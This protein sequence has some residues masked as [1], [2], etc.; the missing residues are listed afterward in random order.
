[1]PYLTHLLILFSI[2]AILALGLNLVVGLTG[3]VS[4][5]HAAFFGVGSYATA[6]LL[7]AS[8]IGFF[9]SLVIGMVIAG[10]L[11][12]I[13]ARILSELSWDYY[14]LGTVGFN[15]IIV[16]ILTNWRSLTRGPLGIPGI[17]R[18]AFLATNTEILVLSLV[19]LAAT[20]AVCSFVRASSF[21]RVLTAIR[22]DE[23]A[24]SVFGYRVVHYKAAVFVIAAALAAVAGSLNAVFITFISPKFDVTLSI[25]IFSVVIFGGLGNLRG[26]LVGALVLVLL[27]E[28]LRFVGFSEDIAA[29]VRQA[30]YGLA[31]V[32]LMLYRPQGIMGKYRL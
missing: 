7:T 24:I 31:L 2:N 15:F 29:Q 8:G 26:S 1:M 3:M 14:V 25:F 21:G 18:P 27:P 10:V 6:L 23:R 11:A 17:P 22:E 12:F 20:Y 19:F 13:I 28:L 5:T 4:I 30:L 16:S 9:P 32:L